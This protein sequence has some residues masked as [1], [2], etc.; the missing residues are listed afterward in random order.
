MLSILLS[1]HCSYVVLFAR[2]GQKCLLQF[3]WVI[4][5]SK[6]QEEQGERTGNLAHFGYYK[7]LHQHPVFKDPQWS[8]PE[9]EDLMS[10]SQAV[11][12]VRRLLQQLEA[13]PHTADKCLYQQT[14]F[15]D[16]LKAQLTCVLH[17]SDIMSIHGGSASPFFSL[18]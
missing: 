7:Q 12:A 2:K 14:A 13:Q 6:S 18:G 8:H 15:W 1:P 11:S 10:S 4:V 5:S 9:P 16:I 17:H 3:S